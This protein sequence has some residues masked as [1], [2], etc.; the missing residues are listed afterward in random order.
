MHVAATYDRIIGPTE[1]DF[2]ELHVIGRLSRRQMQA[3][4]KRQKRLWLAV[5][6][7]NYREQQNHFETLPSTL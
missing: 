6:K 5:A 1:V 2:A 4:R 7:A 3:G